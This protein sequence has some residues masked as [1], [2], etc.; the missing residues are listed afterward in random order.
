[1]NRS[2]LS[3]ALIVVGLAVW[4]LSG[5]GS[6]TEEQ[7][8]TENSQET[9]KLMKVEVIHSAA[10]PVQRLVS[11]Q[12]QIEASQMVKLKAEVDGRVENTPVAEGNRVKAGT[13]LI[14]LA[15]DYRPAQLAEAQAQLRKA[16]SD[17]K[18]SQ[19]LRKR[20]LQA[21]NQIIADR[22]ALESARAQLAQIRYQ[23]QHTRI[24]APFDGVLNLRSVE[25]GDFVERGQQVGELINDEKLIVAG[26]LPQYHVN[27]L[28]VGQEIQIKLVTGEQLNG[29]LQYISATA[30][31]DTRSFRVEVAL[32]NTE[33]QRLIGQSA[34]LLLPV[35]SLDGHWVPSSVLGLDSR[36]DLQVKTLNDD[37][38]VELLSTELIRTEKGGFWIGG[39]PP[40][41]TFISVG[42][43]FVGAGEQVAPVIQEQK[44][45]VVH[46]RNH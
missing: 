23:I 22:A 33:H 46:A 39:L 42:Q 30:D 21:E 17:L 10:Q 24:K 16:Q 4:M 18:A 3:A 35:E 20:G 12:G 40:Q 14:G 32:N 6:Q 43:H 13:E 15:E 38:R 34:T 26:Q 29:N 27:G 25:L 11:V 28:T 44:E 19:Q 31:A 5:M 37:D 2:I 9:A 1:M 45:T 7:A 41:V 36:G 8:E